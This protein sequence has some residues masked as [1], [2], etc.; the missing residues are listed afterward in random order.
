[1]AA[2]DNVYWRWL[3]GAGVSVYIVVLV[4]ATGWFVGVTAD[5]SVLIWA[6]LPLPLIPIMGLHY[7]RPNERLAGWTVFTVWLGSTYAMT[8][9]HNEVMVF[10]LYTALAVAGYYRSPWLLV[11]A[12]FI[13]IAWDFAPRDLPPLLADLP[14]ACM[15]FDGLI[16]IYLL[17]MVTSGR[18][19]SPH[20]SPSQVHVSPPER[21]AP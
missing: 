1:M 4:M 19:V 13:H 18:M 20:I 7:L 14:V 9:I 17:W 2:G 16:G 5:R 12:W 3:R 6:A 10:G 15:I 21:G 11:V 8:G